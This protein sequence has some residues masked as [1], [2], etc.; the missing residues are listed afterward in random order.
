MNNAIAEEKKAKS[1]T[2]TPESSSVVAPASAATE[3]G[4]SE[5]AKPAAVDNAATA[6]TTSVKPSAKRSETDSTSRTDEGWK[7]RRLS[8][9]FRTKYP[10]RK[11]PD[12]K[13]PS[14]TTTGTAPIASSAERY[15]NAVNILKDLESEQTETVLPVADTPE[16]AAVLS[17][18]DPAKMSP[19]ECKA[20]PEV[21][22][23]DA[24]AV[25]HYL[26]LRN[27]VLQVWHQNSKRLLEPDFVLE[28]LVKLEEYASKKD[29]EEWRHRVENIL[30]LLDRMCVINYGLVRPVIM[31]KYRKQ[32]NYGHAVVV[33]GAGIAGLTA[34]RKLK[35]WGFD[36][37]VLEGRSRAGGRVHTWT[38][39]K[40][41]PEPRAEMGAMIITGLEG[42]PLYT[43]LHQQMGLE[44][45]R[46]GPR[47]PL[48]NSQ[49]NP[50]PKFTDEVL[51]VEFNTLLSAASKNGRAAPP[52]SLKI[53]PSLGESLTLMLKREELDCLRRA[54]EYKENQIDIIKTLKMLYR[55]R[56]TLTA[57]LTTDKEKYMKAKVAMT[58]LNNS[59][60][61]WA[62]RTSQSDML[63]T[64]DKLADLNEK[65]K[66]LDSKIKLA[67]KNQPP[68]RYLDTEGRAI[69]GWHEAN[70][71]FANANH[72]DCLSLQHW[73]QDDEYE[74]PGGHFS[75]P[76]GLSH[77]VD[78]LCNGLQVSYDCSV[79]SIEVENGKGRVSYFHH[80][81]KMVRDSVSAVLCT[82]PL[83]VLKR[84]MA[85][86]TEPI[87]RLKGVVHFLPSLP[88]EK[89][90]AIESM[91]Y[92]VLNKVILT[93]KTKFWQ[94]KR[95]LFGFVNEDVQRRGEFFLF[96]SLYDHPTLVVLIAGEAAVALQERC[97]K[98]EV[99]AA[100]QA[101]LKKIFGDDI[102]EPVESV[103]TK[104]GEDLWSCGSYSSVGPG[105]SGANY[106]V[107]AEP[108][109]N[110][111]EPVVFFAGEHTIRNYPATVHGAVLSGLREATRIADTL[112][113]LWYMEDAAS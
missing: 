46:I 38:A 21:Q 91:G 45:E 100:C 22:P 27:A 7:T 28:Q 85:N 39:S 79:C 51:E 24:E 89:I 47:C 42:N 32:A 49:G 4:P 75:V 113:K 76:A 9:D 30:V 35:Q 65:L 31:N 34:A 63:I 87:G 5:S 12:V 67:V 108:L 99:V 107:L 14:P 106:D 77:L 11:Y 13:A 54:R 101:T 55:D 25:Q 98:E 64:A 16:Y 90:R 105:A 50:V 81:Q 53:P 6:T 74:L 1:M 60:T 68:T 112:D 40:V 59:E 33:V 88:D 58:A 29:D 72:L 20:F 69:I 8:A 57:K 110:E 96:W 3:P 19:R 17:R 52:G 56:K 80:C 10:D 41:R 93:Y 26:Q 97:S 104:W 2:P 61:Q 92:G 44:L 62:Y 43:M 23:S 48:F 83:G 66:M 86:T 95:A 111:E 84:S 71:E 103:V 109:P 15:Q 82:V 73:D 36:V 70:L 18:M 37:V 102:E 94:T 78:A